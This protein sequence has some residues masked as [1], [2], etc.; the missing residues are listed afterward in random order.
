MPALPQFDYIFAIGTIFAFL[1][2]WNIGANDVANSFAT[3]VASRSL[4]LKQA[5]CIASV[6]EFA[7][8][9]L[10]GSRVTD[11]IRTKVIS[12]KLFEDDPSVL[13]L[14][15]MCAIVGSATYLTI[16]T[17]F[18]MPV[19]TTH[20]IMG[21]VIGVGIAASG[22]QGINWSFKGVSQVF[23]AWGIAPGISGGFGAIIFLITKYGV[24]RRN[25]PVYKAFFMVPVYFFVTSFLLS[26]LICWKGGS[27]KIDLTDIQAVW[28]SIVVG[29]V[30]A[31]VV[32]T[33]FIPFLYRRI[34]KGDWEL[35]DWQVIQG[36]LLLRRPEP[37]PRPEGMA[38]GNIPDFYAGHL[39]AEE[40]EAK[41][42]GE[43]RPIHDDIE[44]DA[45]H[46]T[47]E[48]ATSSDSDIV[49]IESTHRVTATPAK[50]LSTPKKQPPPGPWYT[51]AAAFWWIKYAVFHGVEQD[52]VSQ[53]SHKDFL[54]GDIEKVHATGEHY[55]NRA[56]YTYSFL[57]IMTAS[58]TSFAHGANDVSNAIGPYT[59]IYFIWS[60]GEISSK[61]PVPLW[62][63]AFGG[64]GIVVGLW[65]YGYNIMR[66]LGNKITLHS[67]ARGFSMELGAAITVIL[68]T[69]LAL[70]VST[71]QCI[72]GATVGVGLCNGT[73][74]TINWRMVAWIYMGW[75][76][77]LPCAGIISGCLM[78]II[79]NAPR[80]GNGV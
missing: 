73:W 55:D 51:P 53:Q 77:T 60:T 76:I 64:A 4:S 30:V 35:K 27:A 72:T 78:G 33:F 20:S 79:L 11:T 17:R 49:P 71:T 63:L 22:P 61:V 57:Q 70:P 23:A 7:G 43:G 67:P 56:E 62:I 18:T 65:T 42:A 24:M 75:I 50:Q 48:K 40:L 21:G 16:A 54:S 47:T 44:K 59:A 52:V 32:A 36:P 29:V 74:R 14:G 34:I 1:D 66:A 37:A 2:A 15:M 9:M 12:T 5:M 68:A 13:M 25:N 38:V 31:L 80:W 3:S 26:L 10:V 8:A 45:I 28:V 41:R 39:T 69:K 46:S 6:M 19:S 58:T